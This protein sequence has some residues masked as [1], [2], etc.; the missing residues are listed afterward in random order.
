MERV[1]RYGQLHSVLVCKLKKSNKLGLKRAETV[2]LLAHITPCDTARGVGA[3]AVYPDATNEVVTYTQASTDIVIDLYS[4][5]CSIGRAWHGT[6]GQKWGIIDRSGE[7]ARTVFA[8]D[9][10]WDNE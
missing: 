3:G 6:A 1:V 4:V 5:E 7:G 9:L 2:F 10:E 8:D